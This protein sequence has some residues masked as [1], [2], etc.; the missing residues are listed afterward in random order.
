MWW[1]LTHIQHS[2]SEK[3]DTFNDCWLTSGLG[4]CLLFLTLT[5]AQE[6]PVDQRLGLQVASKRLVLFYLIFLF[7]SSS[8]RVCIR[9]DDGDLS[10]CSVRREEIVWS[11]GRV[12]SPSI[13]L[14]PVWASKQDWCYRSKGSLWAL[15]IRDWFD[16][17][18]D[19]RRQTLVLFLISHLAY[20]SKSFATDKTGG[21]IDYDCC[22]T[23]AR[24]SLICSLRG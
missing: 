22:I 1:A 14:Q 8:C 23:Y 24:L 10:A 2:K 5:T 11:D 16:T 19:Y 3:D 6:P 7:P 18:V 17:A 13:S 21:E 15:C 4:R 20:S 9:S 12:E